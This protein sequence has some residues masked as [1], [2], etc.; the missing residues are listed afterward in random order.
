MSYDLGLVDAI[1]GEELQLDVPHQMKGGTYCL[2]GCSTADINITYNYATIF[3]RVLGERESDHRENRDGKLC[4]IRLIYGMTGA[5]SIP[6]LE[7]AIEKLGDDVDPDYWKATEGN[8][9]RALQ[10]CLALA[11]LRPDGVWNGD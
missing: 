1:T 9:K 4:G 11:R 10:Q 7:A 8:A 2:G 5:E 6:V 3:R